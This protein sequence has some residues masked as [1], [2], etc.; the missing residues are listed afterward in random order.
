MPSPG[1]FAL[2]AAAAAFGV[3]MTGCTAGPAPT[4]VATPTPTPTETVAPVVDRPTPV[5]AVGCDE[6]VDP[7]ELQTFVGAGVAPIALVTPAE[8]VATISPD[9]AAVDQLG[10][11]VCDWTDGQHSE[12]PWGPPPDP[13]QSVHLSL[14]PDAEAAAQRYVD[15]YAPTS[16]DAAYGATAHGPRCIGVEYAMPTGYCELQGW[17]ADSWIEYVVHGIDIAS[18]D[19]DAQLLAAFTVLTDRAIAAL[20][21]AERGAEWT[22]P[23]SPSPVGDCGSVVTTEDI[24]EL[25]GVADIWVG[26]FWDGP[27]VGQYS[28]AAETEHAMECSFNFV[29]AEGSFGAVHVL[30]EGGWGF[31]SAAQAWL[32]EGAVATEVEGVAPGDALMRC[33]DL[34]DTC[35]LDL[36]IAE[37]WVRIEVMPTPPDEV[38]WVPAGVDFDAARSAIV[39]IAERVV[40]NI[41]AD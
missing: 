31:A 6:L 26:P 2:L 15:V 35:A 40:A 30:P 21:D 8:R 37:H 16:P 28:Y 20:G 4:G 23:V 11:L 3:L 22:P 24:V 1:R 32:A 18:Y 39:P 29:D 33:A 36:R 7:A 14:V 25:T 10:S 17:L 19:T 27:R 41:T 5:F 9:V 38:T 34:A 12:S 13:R